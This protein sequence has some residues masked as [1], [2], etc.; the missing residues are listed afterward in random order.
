MHK[1]LRESTSRGRLVE[2]PNGRTVEIRPLTL[3]DLAQLEEQS[4][5]AHK[6]TYLET[7]SKNIDLIPKEF[8][9]DWLKEAFQTASAMSV[10]SLPSKKTESGRPVEYAFWWAGHTIAGKMNAVWLS[11]RRAD[12]SIK[13]DDLDQLI[14]TDAETLERLANA[15]GEISAPTEGPEGNGTA[16]GKTGQS[17]AQLA[18]QLSSAS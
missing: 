12:P 15:I 1:G 8:L 3:R 10:D 2:L 13:F 14:G 17:P 7:Y 11:L 16:P 9:R 6:R 18:G 5:A 4:L